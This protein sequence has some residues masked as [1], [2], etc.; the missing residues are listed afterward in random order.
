MAAGPLESAD[1]GFWPGLPGVWGGGEGFQVLGDIY[2]RYMSKAKARGGL[3]TR[4][5]PDRS[6]REVDF[7]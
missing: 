3:V 6:S 2:D 1:P 5:G 7:S 4:V